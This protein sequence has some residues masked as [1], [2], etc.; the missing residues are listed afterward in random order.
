M[1]ELEAI[2]LPCDVIALPSRQG[3]GC[4][5]HILRYVK[6][7]GEVESTKYS[8]RPVELMNFRASQGLG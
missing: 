6:S 4:T 3:E 2:M 5:V 1:F 7:R 8:L